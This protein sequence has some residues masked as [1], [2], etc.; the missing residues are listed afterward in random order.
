M[1]KNLDQFLE[2]IVR[3]SSGR[4]HL[5]GASAGLFGYSRVDQELRDAALAFA[6]QCAETHVDLVQIKAMAARLEGALHI[7][8]MKEVISMSELD[9]LLEDLYQLTEDA[10]V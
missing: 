10:S 9:E 8:A 3:I 4:G 1:K 6:A 2:K 7:T 5:G